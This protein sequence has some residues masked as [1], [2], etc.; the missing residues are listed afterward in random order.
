MSTCNLYAKC[1]SLYGDFQCESETFGSETHCRLLTDV[2]HGRLKTVTQPLKELRIREGKKSLLSE[3][4]DG[5]LL[6]CPR[7]MRTNTQIRG[8][9][10]NSE[11]SFWTQKLSYNCFIIHSNLF[12][13]D[14]DYPGRKVMEIALD[15]SERSFDRLLELSLFMMRAS[16]I[17]VK[18]LTEYADVRSTRMSF[19][20]KHIRKIMRSQK[21][22]IICGTCGTPQA[23]EAH[24]RCVSD[25]NLRDQRLGFQ[26]KWKAT[27]NKARYEGV[28]PQAL[29]TTP[30]AIVDT[31]GAE[32]YTLGFTRF[33]LSKVELEGMM[34][35]DLPFGYIFHA[36]D[37]LF[38][39]ASWNASENLG[40]T[41]ALYDKAFKLYNV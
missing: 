11:C 19:Y 32:I 30:K 22:D 7:C 12:Y 31:F 37:Q 38:S 28:D 33:L 39:E 4:K 6:T 20:T 15:I 25:P 36:Y 17:L 8:A 24:C 21:F 40:L 27:I 10:K 13:P 34:F 18:Y 1:K 16:T 5:V 29:M 14:T 41:D 3:N 35:T 26:T 9:C 2:S 23:V